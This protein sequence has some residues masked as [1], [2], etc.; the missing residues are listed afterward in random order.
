MELKEPG[1][2]RVSQDRMR[3]LALHEVW[4]LSQV[5]ISCVSN[6]VR[7]CLDRVSGKETCLGHSRP[8]YVWPG[9]CWS[10]ASGGEGGGLDGTAA[11]RTPAC[12][13]A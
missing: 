4:G 9:V 6:A 7:L 1:W 12:P 13:G 11:Q 3:R 8:V 2:V 10:W 5:V